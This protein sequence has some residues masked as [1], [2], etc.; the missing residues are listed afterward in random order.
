VTCHICMPCFWTRLSSHTEWLIV[1][2][3]PL[4]VVA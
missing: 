1:R 3:R 2:G 4:I